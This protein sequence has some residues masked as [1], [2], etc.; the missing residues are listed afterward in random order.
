MPPSALRQGSKMLIKLP[1]KVHDGYSYY[2]YRSNDDK[3]Y[4]SIPTLS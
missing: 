4:V 3:N 2:T 1:D